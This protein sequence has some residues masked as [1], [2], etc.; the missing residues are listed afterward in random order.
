MRATARLRPHA[1]SSLV[2]VVLLVFCFENLTLSALLLSQEQKA[3]IQARIEAKAQDVQEMAHTRQ[4]F[5]AL[6]SRNRQ[7][8]ASASEAT[9]DEAGGF[10]PSTAN[11]AVAN[12]DVSRR[13][14]LPFI[15]ISTNASTRVDGQISKD[16]TSVMLD[17]SEGFTLSDDEQL[18]RLLG[19]AG[20]SLPAIPEMQ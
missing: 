7:R 19:L 11:T 17:F 3:I 15:L 12:L 9:E 5:Q 8:S 14:K 18:L 20:D 1:H 10:T 16:S 2:L 13:I 4:A 6:F